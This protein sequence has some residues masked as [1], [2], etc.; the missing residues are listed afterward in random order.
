[1]HDIVSNGNYID[2]MRWV[3]NRENGLRE[4]K[5]NSDRGQGILF[6]QEPPP[7]TMDR[8]LIIHSSLFFIIEAVIV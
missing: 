2:V 8:R 7:D 6:Y 1:M 4:E 5:T 3:G